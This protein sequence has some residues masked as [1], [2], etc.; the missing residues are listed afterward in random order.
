MAKRAWL[1]NRDESAMWVSALPVRTR[2]EFL[3][4]RRRDAETRRRVS[5]PY[6]RG[7]N[8]LVERC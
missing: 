7:K 8:C 4:Q 5:A 3:T 6:A 1:V 2:G